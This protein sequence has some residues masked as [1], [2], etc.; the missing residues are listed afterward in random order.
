M[1]LNPA[2][3]TI[4]NN[5]SSMFRGDNSATYGD[6]LEQLTYLY[7]L[8]MNLKFTLENKSNI[9]EQLFFVQ[10]GRVEELGS[11]IINVN[12]YLKIYTP[13][14]KPEFIENHLF[15]TIVPVTVSR[16]ILIDEHL[17]VVDSANL[18]EAISDALN[19]ALKTGE[20]VKRLIKLILS[21][22]KDSGYSIPEIT[23]KFKVSRS[24]AQRDVRLLVESKI[25][26]FK[27]PKKTGKYILTENFLKKIKKQNDNLLNRIKSLELLQHSS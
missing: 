21:I 23:S 4:L 22:Y 9:S 27:G 2:C 7:F 25:L 1:Q 8:K 12:K 24:T 6:Y 16:E 17:A 14:A 3:S 10:L 18:N 13:G 20:V 5:T 19:E 15:K 11:W 26:V